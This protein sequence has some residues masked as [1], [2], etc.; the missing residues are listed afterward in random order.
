VAVFATS[1]SLAAD[2]PRRLKKLSLG[3]GVRVIRVD[4]DVAF[5]GDHVRLRLSGP[6]GVFVENR[7]APLLDGSRDREALAAALADVD[8]LQLNE[9]IDRFVGAGVLDERESSSPLPFL[10]AFQLDDDAV[11]HLAARRIVAVGVDDVESQ[12]QVELRA[13]GLGNVDLLDVAAINTRDQLAEAVA[14]ADLIFHGR[15]SAGL[16]SAHWVN[17]IALASDQRALFARVAAQRATV[18]PLVLP[19]EGPC[20]LCWR[21]RA[22]ANEDD[23]ALA[24]AAESAAGKQPGPRLRATAALPGLAR[25]VAAVAASEIIKVLAALA[26]PVTAAQVWEFDGLT[27]ESH[28]RRVLQ[29][30]DCPACRKKGLPPPVQPPIEELRG[31]AA[32]ADGLTQLTPLLVDVR[33]GVIR[34]LG[35]VPRDP[36]EPARPLVVRAE[37]SN[38]HF[39]RE[40]EAFATASGKGMTEAAAVTSAVGEALERYGS[41]PWQPERIVRSRASTLDLPCVTP[42][43]LGLYHD[44][45]YER[46]PYARWDAETEIGWV[47]GRRLRDGAEVY[48]PA[49][50][51]FMDYS[52]PDNNENLFQVTSNGLAAG[53]TLASA[54]LAAV[55]E[56]LER[57]AF[58]LG[59]LRRLPGTAIDPTDVGPSVTELREVWSRRGVELRLVQLETDQPV[60]VVAAFGIDHVERHDRPA[61]VVGLGADVDWRVAATKASLEVGQVRPAL[62]SR[63]RDP[64]TRRRLGELLADPRAVSDLEDHDLLYADASQVGHL[65][66]WLEA[67]F[68]RAADAETT[69]DAADTLGQLVETLA[70]AGMDV[71]YVNLTPADVASLGIAVVRALVAGLVPIHFGADE[72]RL[73]VS[74]LWTYR[75]LA[76]EVA[77]DLSDLNLQPHPLA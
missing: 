44:P 68:Q 71:V 9:W 38:H 2:D 17:Q 65:G 37:L 66:H 10:Q 43:D 48:V 46:L 32:G 76:G 72:T 69:A 25:V 21:M 27:L 4:D 63:L 39:S 33:V 12:L 35:V 8:K 45:Q 7:L 5:V 74:R 40:E 53:S 42:S 29:R 62:R 22:L 14:G 56:L 77:R 61:V 1:P 51:T 34:R 24:F 6:V 49:W 50:G 57:D 54:V 13:L 60:A 55:Y 47:K 52:P 70:R 19:G 11:A 75:S 58:M 73:A 18:G 67:P 16:E 36:T 64:E 23:Y 30:P 59:W 15:G 41:A 26:A 20:F 3:P 31:A 28:T